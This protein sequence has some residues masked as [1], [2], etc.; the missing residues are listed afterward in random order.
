MYFEFHFSDLKYTHAITRSPVEAERRKQ[1]LMKLIWI[2]GGEACLVSPGQRT[3]CRQ[4]DLIL[5]DK[6]QSF[7]LTPS[8]EA[9]IDYYLTYFTEFLVPSDLTTVVRYAEGIY[10]VADTPIPALFSRFDWHVSNVG[11]DAGQVKMLFRCVLTEILVY[12]SQIAERETA[13]PG[14]LNENIEPVLNFISQNLDKPLQIQDICA[15]FHYSRSHL[16]K[17]FTQVTG[18]PLMHYIRTARANYANQLL[19]S[20]L[21]AMEVARQLG[22]S[23]YSS[24]YRMYRKYLGT[25]PSETRETKESKK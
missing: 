14:M 21:P 10:H 16:C 5:L 25:A 19:R 7:S 17:L 1:S 8:G 4:G 20:G 3:V 15:H 22:Y 9:P 2:S 11:G 23:D 6:G 24:F 18:V 13:I 12:F